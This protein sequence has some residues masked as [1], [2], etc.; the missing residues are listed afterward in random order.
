MTDKDNGYH[1]WAYDPLYQLKS[2]HKWASKTSSTRNWYLD[3]AYDPNGNRLKQ[4]RDGV[5]TDYVYGDNNEMT[6]AGAAD[7][8][9]DNFGSTATI[10]E[11]GTT[12]TLSYDFERHMT[13]ITNGTSA[14]TMEHD[15][16]GRRIKMKLNNASDWTYFVHDELTDEI[17]CEYQI[18]A[19]PSVKALYTWGIGLIS[20]TNLTTKRWFHFDGLGNT[21]ALTSQDETVQDTYQFS[22]FGLPEA[23]SG[24]S[25]NPFRYVGQWGYYDDGARG[26]VHG[27]LLLGIRF[28][29]P[30]WG[31]YCWNSPIASTDP[32]GRFPDWLCYIFCAFVCVGS[33]GTQCLQCLDLCRKA[34]ELDEFNKT[35]D[36]LFMNR[37]KWKAP[38]RTGD[39]LLAPGYGGI[40]QKNCR[41]CCNTL[42][43]DET[44]ALRDYCE[45]MCDYVRRVYRP[46]PKEVRDKPEVEPC[47][48]EPRG[49][50]SCN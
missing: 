11:G 9:F 13:S 23:S 3:W 35:L 43:P 44:S 12:Q 1:K 16:D 46:A 49:G 34:K 29:V 31:R 17:L 14:D 40:F 10:V 39:C 47:G 7:L 42:A 15:G 8:T 24:S 37:P 41:A 38:K 27:L 36:R 45:C 2:E 20:T 50:N 18:P 25:V 19:N 48:K 22:A 30:K 21:L 28:Y 32:S 5:L 6:D 4:W 26:S 33:A